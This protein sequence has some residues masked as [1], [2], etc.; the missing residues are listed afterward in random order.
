V[1]AKAAENLEII[2]VQPIDFEKGLF[3]FHTKLVQI[4]QPSTRLPWL[5]ERAETQH[6]LAI[7]REE[8]FIYVKPE[9]W[10]KHFA[11][12]QPMSK[13]IYFTDLTS[14]QIEQTLRESKHL[15][16]SF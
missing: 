8:G 12:L 15:V 5:S 4:T 11:P 14:P 2:H 6:I 13:D 7:S 1:D 9:N 16:F 3:V 10:N